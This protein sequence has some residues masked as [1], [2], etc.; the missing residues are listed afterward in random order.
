MNALKN[1]RFGPS[2]SLDAHFEG[3]VTFS[4]VEAGALTNLPQ[5][6]RGREGSKKGYTLFRSYSAGTLRTSHFGLYALW[7]MTHIL[8]EQLKLQMFLVDIWVYEIFVDERSCL[9]SEA[10]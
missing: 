4:S 9:V 2:S 10:P 1:A 8:S 3:I 7:E 5:A 6:F